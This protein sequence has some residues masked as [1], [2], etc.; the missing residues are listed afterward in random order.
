MQNVC[1]LFAITTVLDSDSASNHLLLKEPHKEFHLLLQL[2]QVSKI[3]H[4]PCTGLLS[5][6]TITNKHIY[7][8][9]RSSFSS[10]FLNV[11]TNSFIML[12]VYLFVK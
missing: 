9:V 10:R 11:E 12:D 7:K 6:Q 1:C 8:Q 2:C 5:F 3:N 4:F